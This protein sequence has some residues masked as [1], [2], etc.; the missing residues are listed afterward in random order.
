MRRE[1][2]IEDLRFRDLCLDF[3]VCSLEVGLGLRFES[4]RVPGRRVRSRYPHL[5]LLLCVSG[6]GFWIKGSSILVYISSS[7]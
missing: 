2:Y 1:V 5:L 3:G 6:F 7:V 4:L